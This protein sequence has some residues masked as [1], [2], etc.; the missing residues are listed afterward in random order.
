MDDKQNKNRSKNFSTTLVGV[1]LIGLL[2]LPMV[3]TGSAV[4]PPNLISYQGR[5]LDSNGVPLAAASANFQFRFYDAVA[6]GTCLWS[7]DD[8]A[9]L[10]NAN[11][12]VTLT[13]GLFSENLGDATLGV[14]YAA[15]PD[16]VFADNTN[17][18]LEV[19]IEGEVLAPRKQI[20]SA[21]YALN[22][23]T[24][25]GIDSSGFL[26]ST[27][28][29]ATGDYDFTGAEFLGATPLVFEGASN[30]GVVSQFNITDPTGANVLTFQDGTGTVAF[31]SD[32][33]AGAGVWTRAGTDLS[34]T[35]AGDD[36]LMGAG[37]TITVAASTNLFLDA[38]TSAGESTSA[39]DSGGFLIG[40]FDE[41]AN[42]ASTNV[43]DVLDDL[44]AAITGG[45]TGDITRVGSCLTGDCFD[46]TDT[47]STSLSFYDGDS[48]FGAVQTANLTG[49]RIYTLPDASGTVAVSAT[50]PITLSAAGDIGF[51]QTAN[52]T[53]TG[54][55][56]YTGATY[57]GASPLVFEGFTAD[58]FESTFAITD[59]TG[60][61]VITFQD[62]TGT[63]AFLT[64]IPAGVWTRAGTDLSPT[65]AGDD[66][67]MGAGETITVAASTNLFL[68]ADTSAGESTSATDSGAFLIGVFDEF[69]NSNA[70]NVQD[71]LDDLDAAI[72]GGAT[73]DIT[74]VGTCL[75]GDCFDGAD[76]NSTSLSF[77]DG[78]SHFGTM[79]TANIT[80]ARTYTFPDAS[81][82][83]AVSA[84]G[85]VTL[86]AAGD[87]GFDQ[88]AN[89]TWTGQH[90][91]TGAEI[92]GASPFQFE[93]TTDDNIYTTFTITDPTG[94]NVI[95][96]QD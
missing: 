31:L 70:T 52:F 43:Q 61:N 20:V 75:T 6:A 13:D 95:T 54:I 58:A 53:W 45:A 12:T 62:G 63:V 1:L 78:D 19:E 89:F 64:D 8:S 92:L 65:T 23:E 4:T 93:G 66:V 40:V 39:T 46:G 91:Y 87:V 72:T 30:D 34:P 94:A 50:G 71:V 10:A 14:P 86:S 21:A 83:V 88:T 96:F 35:T 5:L 15:I 22:S 29:T 25:D 84:T 36:V 60:A 74:R 17:V 32:I 56:D 16:S 49:A 82:T 85:P 51:D 79:Q 28:D 76:T 69:A 73:G 27:G 42:S 80:G 47:N 68:D 33:P 38:D 90:D 11:R 59:P 24:L 37:E 26:L 41:F 9:C 57:A 81:G 3:P 2:L 7:N 18:W 44:D 48:H 67:L 55:H 77:Y